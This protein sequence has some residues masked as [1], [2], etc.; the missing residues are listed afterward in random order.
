MALQIKNASGGMGAALLVF[1][2]AR[3]GLGKTTLSAIPA[4]IR[5]FEI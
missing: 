5:S 2:C 4:K 3:S 1:A